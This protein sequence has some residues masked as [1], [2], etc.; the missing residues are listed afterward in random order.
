[1]T[2]HLAAGPDDAKRAGLYAALAGDARYRPY[3]QIPDHLHRVMR[4]LR[5]G[6][7]VPEIRARLSA[8]Y[9]FIGVVDDIIDAAPVEFGEPILRLLDNA[10]CRVPLPP[11]ARLVTDELLTY[12][13]APLRAELRPQFAALY[14]AVVAERYAD[15]MARYIAARVACGR[16]TAL[17]SYQIIRPLLRCDPPELP[18]L[19]QDAAGVGCLIDSVLDLPADARQGLLGFR[20]TLAGYALLI[21]RT[22]LAGCQVLARHPRLLALFARAIFDNGCGAR[23]PRAA[24]SVAAVTPL[25]TNT[26]IAHTH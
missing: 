5:A 7:L 26:A 20:P 11:A 12:L 14:E 6:P 2:N 19:L 24:E 22:I 1:M 25:A 15:T 10:A 9:L 16:L 4:Y 23:Q 17:I 8:Y 18:A 21:G 13:D 3:V